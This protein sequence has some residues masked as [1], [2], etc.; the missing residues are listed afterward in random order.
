L[1]CIAD[2]PVLVFDEFAADQD[3]EAKRFFY[4]EV[5]PELKAQGRM[6]VVVTHDDR[7]F[8]LAD[9]IVV[10]ERGVPPVIQRRAIHAGSN[11]VEAMRGRDQSITTSAL[12]TDG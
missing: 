8:R 6:V 10:L 3:P 7:F 11:K 1:A 4:H 12:G 9:Q 5:L 2:V